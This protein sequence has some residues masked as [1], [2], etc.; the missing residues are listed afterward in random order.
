L[1]RAPPSFCR[2]GRVG[3]PGW[4]RSYWLTRSRSG[5]PRPRGEAALK[6]VPIVF[7]IGPLAI[8]T[9]GIGLA[10]T[11]WFGYRYFARRLRKHGYPDGWLGV[12]FVWVIVAAIV[13]ARAVHVI[14]NLGSYRNNPAGIFE[15]WQGGLSSFGGL[16]LALPVGFYSAHRRCPS[17]RLGRA[18]DLLAP[19]LVA[20]WSVGRFLGPQFEYAGGG[21]PTSAWYGL[22]Y[23][24]QI[25]KRIPVPIFQGLECFAIFLILL[26]IERL[27]ARRGGPV[28]FVTSLAVGLWGLSRFFDEYFWLTHDNGT[29]AVEITG[30]AMFVVG[31]A[32]AGMLLARDQKRPRLVAP[33]GAVLDDKGSA[34]PPAPPFG[35]DLPGGAGD[36]REG[37]ATH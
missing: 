32:L 10:I 20:A 3:S 31:L 21:K 11:F 1:R 24:G 28:G 35:S 18:A 12:T 14:A 19:V 36:P 6:P 26:R 16:A 37:V 4:K 13:G 8:H 30:L 9:Y 15:V 33:E 7:H 25:G 5:P 27:I 23:A 34:S 22:S 29:D 17:L 2:E